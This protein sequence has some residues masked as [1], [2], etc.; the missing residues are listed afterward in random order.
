MTIFLDL[1]RYCSDLFCMALAMARVI[2]GEH[3]A[4]QRKIDRAGA[5]DLQSGVIV[6]P[7]QYQ[8]ID[9]QKQGGDGGFRD[10]DDASF[11]TLK[12]ILFIFIE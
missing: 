5:N 11:I 3:D 7:A 4:F 9:D 8:G 12:R 6:K 1:R 2:G 10:D